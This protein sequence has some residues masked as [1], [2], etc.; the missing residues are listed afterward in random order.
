MQISLHGDYVVNLKLNPAVIT[1]AFCSAAAAPWP[2][3]PRHSL[4]SGDRTVSQLSDPAVQPSLHR[5]VIPIVFIAVGSNN[6]EKITPVWIVIA[7]LNI[8][9][10]S[11]IVRS[12]GMPQ[13][14][15]D[16]HLICSFV[17]SAVFHHAL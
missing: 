7:W 16:F 11:G 15:L 5:F 10:D 14:A 2:I 17:A 1:R 4:D 13:H 6:A 3:V 8:P 9:A 12:R